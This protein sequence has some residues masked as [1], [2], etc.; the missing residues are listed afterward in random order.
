MLDKIKVGFIGFGNMAQ[1]LAEG[2]IIKEVIKPNQIYACSKNWEKLYKNTKEKGMNPC[3]TSEELVK[4]SDIVIIAV[5]PYLIPEVITPIKEILKKK[6]VISVAAGYSFEKYEALLSPGTSHLS[7]I[8]NTPVSIGEGIIIAENRH[9]L[10]DEEYQLVEELFSKI[11]LLQFVDSKQLSI[12]G[13]LSGCGPAFTSM[14]IEALADAAVKHGLTREISYKLASQMVAGTG[15][16]QIATGKHPGEMKDAVC[17]PGG[18][19]IVGVATLERKGL[20]SA[21]IDAIDAIETK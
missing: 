17:S 19:T 4:E 8:P 5:K 15:K 10:S 2:L 16:L 21:V 13:T 18:T 11:A 1:A 9:S 6:I 7:T 12:A 20:R 14:F 3:K